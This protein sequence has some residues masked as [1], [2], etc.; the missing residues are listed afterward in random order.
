M[1]SVRV[2]GYCSGTH[3]HNHT[4]HTTRVIDHEADLDRSAQKE[5]RKQLAIYRRAVE[6]VYPEEEVEAGCSTLKRV[7]PLG[8]RLTELFLFVDLSCVRA[9]LGRQSRRGA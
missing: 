7:G 4:D 9:V 6:E 3:L 2:D 1:R 5:Y 8:R